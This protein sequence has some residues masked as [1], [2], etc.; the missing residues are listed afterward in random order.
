VSVVKPSL[1][2]SVGYYAHSRPLI[3]RWDGASW[4]QV[5]APMVGT[6]ETSLLGVAAWGSTGMAVGHFTDTGNNV[7]PAAEVLRNGAWHLATPHSPLNDSSLIDV[8][9]V[10]GTNTAWAVGYAS[11]Q[12]QTLVDFWNGTGWKRFPSPSPGTL[13]DYLDGIAARSPSD[14][15]AVGTQSDGARQSTL[16]EHW[17]G[18]AWSVVPS[19][20]AGTGASLSAVVASPA[21]GP[22][23][24]AVGAHEDSTG[25]NRTLTERYD[26][27][28]WKIIPSVDPAAN[29]DFLAGVTLAGPGN[30][31]L[32]A[33]GYRTHDNRLAHTLL[34]SR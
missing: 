1:A 20:D 24:W 14:V 28:A 21:L 6:V 10:P 7:H 27:S 25:A 23:A 26:G 15:W 19:P 3:E 33:G 2:W 18:A 11:N 22:R 9:R 32:A 34:E 8:A 30:T 12:T 13:Y 29:S 5:T 31:I 4:S 16:I 17:N